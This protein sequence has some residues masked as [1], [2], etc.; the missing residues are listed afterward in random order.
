M[1]GYTLVT[2]LDLDLLMVMDCG[3]VGNDGMRD[4]VYMNDIHPAYAL[5]GDLIPISSLSVVHYGKGAGLS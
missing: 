4:H 2:H 5:H 3:N 1:G